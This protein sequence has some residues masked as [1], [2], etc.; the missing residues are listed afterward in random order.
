MTAKDSNRE[1]IIA[2]KKRKANTRTFFPVFS[3]KEFVSSQRAGEDS[4]WLYQNSRYTPE[5]SYCFIFK[6]CLI[7]RLT[8]VKC[9]LLFKRQQVSLKLILF[10]VYFRLYS[11]L[12]IVDFL[13][14]LSFS[15]CISFHFSSVSTLVFVSPLLFFKLMKCA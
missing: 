1:I 5:G 3:K 8:F 7:Q 11:R 2:K 15:F 9:N 13:P 6:K 12:T 14:L 4:V 10:V